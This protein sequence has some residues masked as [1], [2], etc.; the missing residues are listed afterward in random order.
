MNHRWAVILVGALATSGCTDGVNGGAGGTGGGGLGGSSGVGGSGGLAGSGGTG[1]GGGMGGGGGSGAPAVFVAPAGNDST[2]VRGD[3]SKPCASLNQ[4][5]SLVAAGERIQLAG[6][7]YGAAFG[8]NMANQPRNQFTIMQ[9]FSSDTTITIAAGATAIIP[10]Q[11][12]FGD[13]DTGAGGD[14]LGFDATGGRIKIDGFRANGDYDF[15]RN[16]DIYCENN[17]PYPIVNGNCSAPIRGSG[18]FF[19]MTGGS[20]GPT[21]A[22]QATGLED[23]SIGYTQPNGQLTGWT[24]EGVW[25]HDANWLNVCNGGSEACHTENLY[26]N[27]VA[28]FTIKN[29]MFTNCGNSACIFTTHQGY[30]YNS[31]NIAIVGNIMKA[32]RSGA[33]IDIA[34]GTESAIIAY[35][36]FGNALLSSG[37]VMFAGNIASNNP[38]PGTGA[39]ITFD[40][41]LWIY[42]TSGGGSADQ[43]GSTD[44]TYNVPHDPL[45]DI[46]V[47]WSGG[48]YHLKGGTSPAVDFGNPGNYTLASP[49]YYGQ[50]RFCG[51]APDVGAVERCP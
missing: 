16:V 36:T 23:S 43:C 12:N 29:S 14:H 37:T 50:T 33:D 1:G 47:S 31:K 28:N 35:N 17:A 6:G 40:H 8:C 39:T 20:V 7:T 3:P 51:A 38:C 5:L 2:C 32:N 24:F 30:P 48:D 11:V 41:N 15:L 26:L 21:T 19:T 46:Y 42:D 44:R 18:N 10:C 27:A 49:D 25:F 22:G 45:A 4:A 13:S 9:S 34:D